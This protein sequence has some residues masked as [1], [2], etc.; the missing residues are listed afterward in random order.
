M[1]DIHCHILP[2]LDDGAQDL[3]DTVQMARIAADCGITHI[4]ATPHCNIP[5]EVNNYIGHAYAD[6]L[7]SAREA[8]SE[9]YIPVKLLSGMEVFVTFDLPDLIRADKILTLNHSDYM[10]IEFDFGEDP[11][12][13]D[14]MTDRLL[15]MKLVPV[16][17]HPE[18]YEFIKYDIEFALRLRRKGCL[19][20]ANKD[21]FLG[22]YGQGAEKASFAL[23]RRNLITAVASDAHSPHHRT[24][25]NRSAIHALSGDFDVKKLFSDTPKKI[26]LNEYVR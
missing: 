13:V 4:V 1:T 22:K 18:R 16:I 25:D 5:G 7:Q 9:A 21:S 2:G 19:F 10:L 24:P 8:I 26:I 14:F 3:S 23:L 15:E 11:D 17:A 20:Q 6:A 12:F